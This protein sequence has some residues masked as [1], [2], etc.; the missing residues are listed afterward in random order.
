[1]LRNIRSQLIYLHPEGVYYNYN[2]EFTDKDMVRVD[3]CELK[4]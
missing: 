1:M 3:L 2:N 4:L